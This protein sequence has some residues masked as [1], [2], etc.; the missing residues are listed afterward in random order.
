MNL[1]TAKALRR[2]ARQMGAALPAIKYLYHKVTGQVVNDPK[3]QRAIYRAMKKH[4]NR[5]AA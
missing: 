4:L 2:V 1:K 3:S 5:R